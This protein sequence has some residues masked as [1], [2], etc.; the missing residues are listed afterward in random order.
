MGRCVHLALIL[1]L[2]AELIPQIDNRDKCA[3]INDILH[4]LGF[5]LIMPKLNMPAEHYG[6][7]MH[8][9]TVLGNK[10]V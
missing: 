10:Y 8:P 9:L 2:L 7:C 1:Y 6:I 5:V 3:M 4:P